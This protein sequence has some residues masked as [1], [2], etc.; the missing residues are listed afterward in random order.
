MFF[1][2]ERRKTLRDEQPSLKITE[3]SVI[4]G[5]E[6]KKLDDNDKE[7]YLKLA[8]DDKVRYEKEKVQAESGI[9]TKK[10]VEDEEESKE[11]AEEDEDEEDDE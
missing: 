6:W 8:K 11:E 4:I 7:P 10:K 9:E 2:S 3:A 1:S 5:A